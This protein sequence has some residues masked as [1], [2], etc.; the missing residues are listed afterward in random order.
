MA[1]HKGDYTA[2]PADVL[3]PVLIGYRPVFANA[4]FIVMASS[5]IGVAVDRDHIGA[6]SD[7]MTWARAHA[8]PA[9][10]QATLPPRMTLAPGDALARMAR[11]IA[12]DL[13]KPV[14]GTGLTAVAETALPFAG[15]RWFWGDDAA[16]VAELFCLPTLR[17]VEPELV[18][19]LI[20]TILAL[21]RD[22]IIQRRLGPAE[23]RVE[24][25]E[26]TDFRVLGTFVITSGDLSRGRVRQAIRFN[27]GRTRPIVC[28][29]PG[30]LECEWRGRRLTCDIAAS[31]FAH[32]IEQH[33]DHVLLRHVSTIR[34]PDDV[35]RELG[36]VTCTYT[37]AAGRSA[38]AVD[39]VV[40]PARFVT[41][42]DISVT[43]G[44]GELNE[45]GWFD[46]ITSLSEMGDVAITEAP[47][48][49]PLTGKNPAYF[50]FW[51]SRALPGHATGVHIVPDDGPP[52][53][54][55]GTVD[56]ERI[57]SLQWRYRS[58]SATRHKPFVIRDERL[59]T[60][61]GYYDRAPE[62]RALVRETDPAWCRDPSM[63][64]DTGV[65]LNAVATWLFFAI[66]GHYG[67]VPL[68][69][70]AAL[71]AWYDRHL[72]LYLDHL[73]LDEP[74]RHERI[75]VRGLAFAI[76]S[77]DTAARAFPDAC[78][79]DTADQLTEALLG[80]E[81]AVGG[82]DD[83][84]IFGSGLPEAAWRPELDSQC[85]ALLALGRM[86]YAPEAAAAL[87]PAI[88]RGLA[89]LRISIPT[90]SSY[91]NDPLDHPT[92]VIGRHRQDDDLIDTGFW[93]YKLGLA[94]RAFHIIA[95]GA[96]IGVINLP[97]PLRAHLA[98]LDRTAREALLYAAECRN[99]VIEVRTSFNAG[100]TNSETQPWVA[101][102]LVSDL[103]RVIVG[104]PT[105]VDA[106]LRFFRFPHV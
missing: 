25:A 13:V 33:G 66:N 44:L 79:R 75:F 19:R 104:E 50:G 85:A 37:L 89:A 11:L 4:V 84:G 51:E 14:K 101:L 93:T 56:G 22:G 63:T 92:I 97:T 102:G 6:L 71:R 48:G 59:V 29:V 17:A 88:A 57:A 15:T 74:N 3:Y 7:M 100:E 60:A 90:G 52:V 99:D 95:H 39:L 35:M 58:R 41:L 83:A 53:E 24:V 64:Y 36:T 23:A 28:F 106:S 2:I 20:D 103:E 34:H 12:R 80:T 16:K 43:S 8:T 86:A 82:I 27:D 76:L 87:S 40:T 49:L 18:D 98:D 105:M 21:S 69:R 78:Y 42:R 32:S 38:V 55:A 70:I 81:V 5:A 91:G 96:E 31:I 73:R 94:L 65:E 61:G 10:V 77:L 67:N 46:T 47:L 62:Y 26:T 68:A 1:I 30:T 9:I 45:L 54:I 72:A